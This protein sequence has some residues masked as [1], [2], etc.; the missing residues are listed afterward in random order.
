MY[1]FYL[2]EIVGGKKKKMDSYSFFKM[3]FLKSK[4]MHSIEYS[5]A[6]WYAVMSSVAEASCESLTLVFQSEQYRWIA[7][8]HILFM[9][10]RLLVAG[11]LS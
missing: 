9:S 1:I 3:H 7:A 11:I 8:S 10:K 5:L 4:A 6:F 2:F